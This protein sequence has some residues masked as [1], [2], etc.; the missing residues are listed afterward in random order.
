VPVGCGL[1]A[2]VLRIPHAE[3]LA[4]A[5]NYTMLG[6]DIPLDF[7]MMEFPYERYDLLKVRQLGKGVDLDKNDQALFIHEDVRPFRETVFLPEESEI[8]RHPSMRPKNRRG[9]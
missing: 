2:G 6:R 4:L 7:G 1:D 8:L 9:S 3:R 5:V